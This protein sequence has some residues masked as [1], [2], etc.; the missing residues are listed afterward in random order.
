M[1]PTNNLPAVYYNN[2]IY[3]NTKQISIA[4]QA[5]AYI[6]YAILG[7]GLICDK[8]VG[9]ELFG[10]LQLAYLSMSNLKYVQPL[11]PPLMNMLLVNGYNPTV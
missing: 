4:F 5:S 10:V 7:I 9:V 1:N 2:T 11:L 6:S 8:I 3:Q